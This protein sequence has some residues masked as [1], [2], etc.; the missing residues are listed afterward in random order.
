[1]FKNLRRLVVLFLL[2]CTLSSMAFAYI[3]DL[4]GGWHTDFPIGDVPDGVSFSLID[5]GVFRELFSGFKLGL[6]YN[7]YDVYASPSDFRWHSFSPEFLVFVHEVNERIN[8]YVRG[9]AGVLNATS[10]DKLNGTFH[11]LKVK[12]KLPVVKAGAG[13][14][15]KIL[16]N[17]NGYG[18]VLLQYAKL[19]FSYESGSTSKTYLALL[20]GAGVNYT[21]D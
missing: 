1:M 15:V 2:S 11:D 12:V 20:F 4:R 13:C 8:I 6:T 17:L 5:V 16:E 7:F 10:A 3:V 19:K 14:E 21:L 18:D 9:G